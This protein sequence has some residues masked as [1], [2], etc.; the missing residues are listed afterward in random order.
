MM[1]IKERKQRG[2]ETIT[3]YKPNL[4]LF[5]S[6]LLRGLNNYRIELG[7]PTNNK[8]IFSFEFSKS[9][10]YEKP[11]KVGY[12]R[13]DIIIKNNGKTPAV[14]VIIKVD[15][16]NC[17]EEQIIVISKEFMRCFSD[18]HIAEISMTQFIKRLN[19]DNHTNFDIN[20]QEIREAFF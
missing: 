6:E 18:S 14:M 13:Y 2:Y 8:K 11:L 19:Q 10:D 7:E 9:L 17:V 5:L 4:F 15:E 1:S 12:E 20:F 3:S 16:G